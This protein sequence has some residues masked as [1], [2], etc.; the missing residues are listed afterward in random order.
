M[1]HLTTA[2]CA[3]AV[4]VACE[5][6]REQSAEPAP[7]EN[8]AQ[9]QASTPEA[10]KAAEAKVPTS[11]P[12]QLQC[13]KDG[14]TLRC[15]IALEPNKRQLAGM[16]ARIAFDGSELTFKSLSCP[17]T[18]NNVDLCKSAGVTKTGHSITTRASTK[19]EGKMALIAYHPSQPKL[20]LPTDAPIVTLV[21]EMKS[22]NTAQGTVQITNAVGSDADANKIDLKSRNGR[23][24]IKP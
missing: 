6:P 24:A 13:A 16:Q 5:K 11:A 15:P 23:L 17:D 10:T 9:V 3:V 19:D 8:K 14:T 20:A 2:L 22:K 21:F 4:L 12:A 7:S 18:A 1:R